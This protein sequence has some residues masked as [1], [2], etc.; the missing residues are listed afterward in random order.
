MPP[1][2]TAD[3]P[4]TE[5]IDET[6]SPPV[7]DSATPTVQPSSPSRD[8]SRSGSL[9]RP[10]ETWVFSRSSGSSGSPGSGVTGVT[11]SPPDRAARRGSR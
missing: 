7:S 10:T 11:A 4:G 6:T 3:D 8:T 2:S 1:R 5:T 9:R